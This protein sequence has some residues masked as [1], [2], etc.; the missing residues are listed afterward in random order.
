MQVGVIV[1]TGLGGERFA[2]GH[3]RDT[4]AA[5]NAMGLGEGDL[6][7]LQRPRRSAVHLVP[8]HGRRR[9]ASRPLTRPRNAGSSRPASARA[10][11][12][13]PPRRSSPPTTSA[14][15][16]TEV[17]RMNYPVWDIPASGL[18][19]AVI[20]ILHVFVSHFAVGGGLYL[21]L[22]E[23]KARRDGDDAAARLREAA[24]PLLHPAHAGL[25][26]HHRRRHL[27]HHRP[28]ASAGHLVAHQ[29]LR[30]GMGDR[31]DLL[32]RRDRGRDG[33]LLRLGPPVG[34]G[35]HGRRLDLRRRRRGSAWSSSTASSPSC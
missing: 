5:I 3:E 7:L 24:Q 15:S 32:R 14:S 22:V 6:R 20:A 16:P 13:P 23:R 1:M 19:I 31:V 25:R 21:V 34:A 12:S 17:R 27:V 28:R 30:L 35:A 2:E 33:L 8:G 29:H 9:A 11:A 10:S 26:R 18:L 4:V